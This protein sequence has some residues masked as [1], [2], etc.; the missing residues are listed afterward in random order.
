MIPLERIH[1]AAKR[2]APHIAR[3][4]LIHSPTLSRMFDAKIYLKLENL[5]TTGSFKIRGATLRILAG[6]G[7]IGPGGV[8]AAS[9]GN[10]A[11]GVALAA[12]RAG[13]AATIVMPEWVS[14]TKQ[15]ATRGYGGKVVIHGQS[16]GESLEMARTLAA[17]GRTFIHPFDD[18]DIIAGQGTVGLEI[19]E[20]LPEADIIL[21]PVGGGGLIS[22]VASAVLGL[23]PGVRLIGVQAAVC[24]A[25]CASV[26]AGHVVEVAGGT[27]IAD[28]IAVKKPGSLCFDI[29]SQAVE[30]TVAV[31]EEQIAAAVL[32]LLERKKILAEGAGAAPLAALISGAVSLPPGANTVLVISGGNVDSP[33]L[34]R[35]ISQGLIKHGRVMRVRVP[36][37]DVPGSLAKL[38]ATVAGLQANVLR[39]HH[40]RGAGRLSIYKTRVELDL[41][42]RGPAHVEEVKTQL[43][44]AGYGI[45]ENAHQGG[46]AFE[47][48]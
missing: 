39:I 44:A 30:E 29:I 23:L 35:I 33:L 18:S 24:P 14:I 40:D 46:V 20:D 5:Q 48:K 38:L 12:A 22:G 9:A 17:S 8:V 16:I 37:K 6:K 36:L 42:T 28:G 2:L 15:E 7:A 34:G 21:C 13:H 31:A 19:A 32:M 4:P 45:E 1:R 43:A 26:R 10:H 25:V 47:S 11:Q 3:T 27:S 41:E